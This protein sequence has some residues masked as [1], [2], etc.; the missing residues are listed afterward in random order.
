MSVSPSPNFN[1]LLGSSGGTALYSGDGT[2]VFSKMRTLTYDNVN[3][4]VTMTS[5]GVFNN[6]A[7][8]NTR[9]K[10]TQ[11]RYLE[12]PYS[13]TNVI[14]SVLSKDDSR[15]P[16]DVTAKYNNAVENAKS[17]FNSPFIFYQYIIGAIVN[18]SYF[19]PVGTYS[20]RIRDN[21]LLFEYFCNPKNPNAVQYTK[22]INVTEYFPNPADTV[23]TTTQLTNSGFYYNGNS[24]STSSNTYSTAGWI[25]VINDIGGRNGIFTYATTFSENIDSRS[26]LIYKD[27]TLYVRSAEWKTIDGAVVQDVTQLVTEL[28]V[29]ALNN[30]GSSEYAT[31]TITAWNIS[32]L[33]VDPLDPS[34]SIAN[35]DVML[36]VNTNTYF[37]VFTDIAPGALKTLYMIV[38]LYPKGVTP[39][40]A[41]LTYLYPYYSF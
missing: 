35:G 28:V 26:I 22:L 1:F 40:N 10:Y 9:M 24:I 23:G 33:P 6:P 19:L 34:K 15:E 17:I 25:K 29:D 11:T 3:I 32:D 18:G 20:Y 41:S 39:L 31:N 21:K 12:S 14:S 2:T 36:N 5:A 4:D 13:T 7:F 38:D 16:L 8:P 37:D 30:V 27:Y